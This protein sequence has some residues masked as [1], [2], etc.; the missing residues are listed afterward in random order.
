MYCPINLSDRFCNMR[1]GSPRL[2]LHDKISAKHPT[3]KRNG[4]LLEIDYEGT[5]VLCGCTTSDNENPESIQAFEKAITNGSAYILA[6]NELQ[7]PSRNG[8]AYNVMLVERDEEAVDFDEAWVYMT[9]EV[10]AMQKSLPGQKTSWMILH[11]SPISTHDQSGKTFTRLLRMNSDEEAF[12]K[13]KGSLHTAA[14]TGDEIG[15]RKCLAARG[16][17]ITSKDERG[18]MPLH[19]AAYK[20]QVN[21]IRI[22]KEYGPSIDALDSSQRSPLMI[23]AG[24]GHLEAVKELLRFGADVNLSN[25]NAYCPLNQAL[26]SD[27]EH[28]EVVKAL[29]AAGARPNGQDKFGFAPMTIACER[30]VEV[31]NI[32]ISA[33]ADPSADLVGGATILHFASRAGNAC[34]SWVCQ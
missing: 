30:S 19:A 20:G 25:K 6:N 31:V 13:N 24:E 4:L 22:L 28:V 16:E 1:R 26:L 7:F 5:G 33:G 18:W 9:V 23:A 21:S 27:Q 17:L 29:L 8:L 34:L 15:I 3:E 14:E 11:E 10:T 32:L 12:H 2:T